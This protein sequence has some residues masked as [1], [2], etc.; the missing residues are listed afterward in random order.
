MNEFLGI[1]KEVVDPDLYVVKFDIPGKTKDSTAFPFRGEVDEPRKGDIVII[2][3]YDDTGNHS[4]YLYR[5]LKEN[6]FIGIRSRGKL[7]KFSKESLTLAIFS[8]NSDYCDTGKKD[9]TPGESEW[10]S[11]IKLDSSGNIDI[12]AGGNLNI[13]VDGETNMKMADSKFSGSLEIGG[14]GILKINGT[15]IPSGSGGPLWSN[16]PEAPDPGTPMISGDSI[17]LN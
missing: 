6:D 14:P 10:V 9:T 13:S 16:I 3:E 2:T 15:T 4:Y 12:H 11:W 8:E 5:K 7:I 17:A 1:I